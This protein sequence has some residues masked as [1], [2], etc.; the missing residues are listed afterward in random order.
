VLGDLKELY[1]LAGFIEGEGSFILDKKWGKVIVQ[2]AQVQREPLERVCRMVGGTLT[3]DYA[4]R[5]RPRSQ[6]IWRWALTGSRAVGLSMTLYALMSPR[7]KV[8]IR[9]ALDSWRAHGVYWKYRTHCFKGHPFV[10]GNMSRLLMKN[11]RWRRTCLT[12][13]AKASAAYRLQRKLLSAE[14][15]EQGRLLN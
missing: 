14:I 7:R 10:E 12:C 6:D 8:Q 5:R 11:G 4:S 13:Q 3:L 15:P 2:I 9:T 1:W